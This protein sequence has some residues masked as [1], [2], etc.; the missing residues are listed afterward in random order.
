MYVL[1]RSA[2]YAHFQKPYQ[3]FVFCGK[4][5]II[6]VLQLMFLK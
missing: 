1:S 5:V 6:K 4:S 3:V 2:E